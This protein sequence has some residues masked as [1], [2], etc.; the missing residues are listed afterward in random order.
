MA[1][2][3][4]NYDM[5]VVG[6]GFAGTM[7]TLNFLETCQKLGKSGRVALVE[8]GKSDERCGAS[9]WT[10]AYLRL[11][12]DL[13]FDEDW[14]HEM[15]MVSKGEADQEYCEKLGQEAQATALY[16]QD[17]G[18]TFVHHDEENV[19]LEFK[20]GQHFVFPDGGGNAIITCLMDHIK[21]YPNCDIHWETEARHLITTNKGTIKGLLV[22]KKDGLIYELYAP[23][24]VLACGGFEGNREMLA[25]YVGRRTH[26]L[27]LIAPG[28][29]H[30]KGAGLNMAL[31][32][33]AATAGSFD[34]MHCELVDTRATKPDAVI[35]GHNYGIVVNEHC[36]RFYDEGKR[37]LFA[38][39]EMIALEL[40]RDQN[41][42]G[43]FITDHT[44]MKRF[45]PGWV[46]DTTDQE[47]EQAD[48]IHDLAVKLRIDP[49]ELEKTVAEF[50]AACND[51]PFDL[52][53][54]DGKATTGLSP[55][56]SNWA[57]P[58]S[59]PPYYGYPVT[60]HLT[61]TYGGVKTNTDAQVLGT[62]DVPIPGLWAAGEMTGLYYNEKLQK[63]MLQNVAS[64]VTSRL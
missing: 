63:S 37:H 53:K 62:N 24:V 26:E 60:A 34:G 31:E 22:R 51:K 17:H 41:Q 46:Y 38:T 18:V 42:K 35:W 47:P 4:N 43:Y 56:K 10:M 20:T 7:A 23:N 52:M 9:R 29:K 14:K 12:K 21:K 48:T 49:D 19:L 33:G 8:V 54:L 28:I 58:I 15:K 32:V 5:I 55:N 40:W 16:V 50:N 45:R 64:K 39:F 1:F 13:R 44:V 6:S 36:K 59:T 27:P 11:D 25:K 57:N 30:N 2:S 3:S 61:F